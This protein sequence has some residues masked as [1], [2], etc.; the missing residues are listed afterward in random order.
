MTAAE[1]VAGTPCRRA[2]S[3][4][5]YPAARKQAVR[6]MISFQNALVG[7]PSQGAPARRRPKRLASLFVA[8]DRP[9]LLLEEQFL[10]SALLEM[11]IEPQRSTW[12]MIS[13]NSDFGIG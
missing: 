13:S 2:R 3:D 1:L 8:H 4:A 12:V 6:I 10:R 5:R 9:N 7:D 11:L